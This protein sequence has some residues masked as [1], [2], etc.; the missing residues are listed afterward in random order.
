MITLRIDGMTCGGCAKSV[1]RALEKAG[2]QVDEVNHE[3]GTARVGDDVDRSAAAA[4]L[5]KA[6][7]TLVPMNAG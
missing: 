4:A 3:E 2:V 5:H 1:R 6:G 7:F